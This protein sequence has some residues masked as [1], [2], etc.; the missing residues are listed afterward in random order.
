MG[1]QDKILETV[2]NLQESSGK[3]DGQMELLT[4]N[5]TELNNRFTLF[6]DN[7]EETCP[8]S[9]REKREQRRKARIFN[10]T[11]IIAGIAIAII[12]AFPDWVK[13]IKEILEVLK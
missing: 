9:K 10:R 13:F 4:E 8:I 2:M 12:V 7:R 5:V 6:Q 11:T 1:V 3:R